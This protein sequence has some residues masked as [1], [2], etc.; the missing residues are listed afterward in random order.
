MPS[1]CKCEPL[2][3]NEANRLTTKSRA[4]ILPFSSSAAAMAIAH[5][6]L[7]YYRF[8]LKATTDIQLPA[9]KGSSFRGGFG[10]ALKQ[11]F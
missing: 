10:H 8:V 6:R 9:Y 3:S 11:Q 2:I 4:E 1:Q 5:F 7:A